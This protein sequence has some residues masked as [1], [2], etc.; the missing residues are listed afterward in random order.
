ME[1]GQQED[2]LSNLI[3]LTQSIGCERFADEVIGFQ[4]RALILLPK[5]QRDRGK[6]P[7]LRSAICLKL[8][9]KLL[10]MYPAAVSILGLKKWAHEVDLEDSAF[11]RNGNFAVKGVGYDTWHYLCM[12][13][14][15]ENLAKPDVHIRRFVKCVL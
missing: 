12:L 1:T 4:A 9:Q 3:N 14:G 7:P 10:D 15:N 5:N 6:K 8:A 13:A 11:K 2:T